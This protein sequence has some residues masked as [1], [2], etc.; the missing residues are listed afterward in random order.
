MAQDVIHTYDSVPI[1]AKILE[2]GDDYM[3]YKTWDNPDGPL[4]N[5]SLSRVVKIVFE[6]GTTKTFA[7]I[8]PY[9]SS[10]LY[11]TYPLDYRWGQSLSRSMQRGGGKSAMYAGN[12]RFHPE[13]RDECLYDRI[14]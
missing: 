13:D 5:M 3:Y 11:G 10:G 12:D 9:I 4:Y 8:S 6:N 7:S 1:K 14:R 2:I